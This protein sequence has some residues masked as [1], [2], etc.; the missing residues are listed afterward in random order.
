MLWQRKTLKPLE[1]IART[2]FLVSLTSWIVFWLADLVEPGFVSRSFSVHIFLLAAIVCGWIWS[3][4]LE[5]Y[6]SRPRAQ[7]VVGALGGL[8]MAVLTWNLSQDLGIYRV[9]LALLS[10]SVPTM[11]YAL[12][13]D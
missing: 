7:A 11:V 1:T 4:T 8:G 3:Q 5:D 10:A 12:M 13:R 9:P 2:G 6:T